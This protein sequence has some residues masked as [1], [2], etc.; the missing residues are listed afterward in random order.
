MTLVE[1]LK[2]RYPGDVLVTYVEQHPE[3]TEVLLPVIVSSTLEFDALQRMVS[4]S[5]KKIIVKV[6]KQI[7][8]QKL[9]YYDGRD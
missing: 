9:G 6:R 2:A 1:A 3:A 4:G 5:G 7:G 8:K